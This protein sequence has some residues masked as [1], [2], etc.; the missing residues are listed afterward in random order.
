MLLLKFNRSKL[1]S[2]LRAHQYNTWYTHN[3][4]IMVRGGGIDSKPNSSQNNATICEV[5]RQ[6]L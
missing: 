1:Y 4:T 6:T 2:I 5:K 3:V